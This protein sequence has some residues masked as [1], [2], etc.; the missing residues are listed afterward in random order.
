MKTARIPGIVLAGLL[1]AL[2]RA[3]AARKVLALAEVKITDSVAAAAKKDG[4]HAALTRVR[5][6]IDGQLSDAFNATRKFEIAARGDL[7]ALQEEKALTGEPLVAAKADY[8]VVPL[9]DDFR[10]FSRTAA[11]PGLGKAVTKRKIRLGM[12]VRIYDRKTQR[13]V[14]SV[15]LHIEAADVEEHVR[16]AAGGRPYS[17]ELL[18]EIARRAAEETARRVVDVLYPARV[19]GLA[20]KEAVINRGEGTGVAPGQLW[21]IFAPGGEMIDPDTGESLGCNEVKVGVLRIERVTPKFAAGTLLENRGVRKG[22]VAR[23]K[24]PAEKQPAPSGE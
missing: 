21:E 17:D 5:E 3:D 15:S 4:S 2:P 8:L 20:G 14:E 12:V 1:L 19:V 9:I 23:R 11:F 7:D 18:R 6:A 13:M 22:F 24:E 10:D 16:R